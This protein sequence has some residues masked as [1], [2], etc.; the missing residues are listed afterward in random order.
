MGK[1][2]PRKQRAKL[3]AGLDELHNALTDGLD[4]GDDE[5]VRHFLIKNWDRFPSCRASVDDAVVGVSEVL[6]SVCFVVAAKRPR[7][8]HSCQPRRPSPRLYELSHCVD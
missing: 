6:E 1:S 3:W 2:M 4:L 8:R 5:A 7:S